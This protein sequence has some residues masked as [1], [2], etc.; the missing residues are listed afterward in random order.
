MPTPGAHVVVELIGPG[1]LAWSRTRGYEGVGDDGSQ[2]EPVGGVVVDSW[3][4]ADPETGEVERRLRVI[5]PYRVRPRL[6]WHVLAESEVDRSTLDVAGPAMIGKLYR[7]LCEEVALN[8]RRPRSGA[9]MP[10]HVELAPI[11]H[12]LGSLLA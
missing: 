2:L 9:V 11:I 6:T 8:G 10:E 4:V 12:R 1:V 7:R 5:D 3:D